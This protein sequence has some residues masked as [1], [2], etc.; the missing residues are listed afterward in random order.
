MGLIKKEL[1]K[2]ITGW[3]EIQ[4]YNTDVLM[5]PSPNPKTKV[6]A[7]KD[8]WSAA[9]AA[10]IFSQVTPVVED[11]EWGSNEERWR[12]AQLDFDRGRTG[13]RKITHRHHIRAWKDCQLYGGVLF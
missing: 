3:R 12:T 13:L 9:E 5:S 1:N 7:M 11:E 8:E 4:H 10:E 6:S 2:N